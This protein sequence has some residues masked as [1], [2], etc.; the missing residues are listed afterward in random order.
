MLKLLNFII[1]ILIITVGV[2]WLDLSFVPEP[3]KFI[4]NYIPEREKPAPD[5]NF[6]TLS[7]KDSSLYELKEDIIIIN[8]WASWCTPCIKE[9][10]DLIS[11]T[12]K[13][14][15]KVALVAISIDMSKNKAQSLLTTLQKKMSINTNHPNIYWIWDKNQKISFD[16]FSTTK[17]PET[18][19]IDKNRMMV[20]KI[21]GEY[22]WDSEKAHNIIKETLER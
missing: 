4:D 2:I 19:I 17:V 12:K 20:K 9:M 5:F 15:G 8:F 14:E 3:P 11:L 1:F 7:G 6:S 10:P 13:Y 22:A 18:I 21:V 16:K